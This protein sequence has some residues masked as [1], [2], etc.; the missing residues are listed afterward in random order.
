MRLII[1]SRSRSLY[2]TRRL[3]EAA[4][5]RGYQVQIIDPL[6]CSLLV[7][8]QGAKVLHRQQV[9][10]RPNALLARIGAS[11]TSYGLTV[12]RQFESQGVICTNGSLGIATARDK[13]RALQLLS[14]HHLP[15]PTTAFIRD[16][17]DLKAAIETVGGLPVVLKVVEGTQ[18]VGVMLADSMPMAASI[19]DTFLRQGQ[20]VL[21]QQ[22]VA[23]SK[24]RDVRAFV[25]G[26][27][28]VAAMLRQASGSEF[29][30][31]LHRG[32]QAQPI[33][34][35]KNY[36]D[37][38]LK[39]AHILSLEVAGVDLLLS[40]EGPKVLEVN[41]SP[42]LEGIE[43]ASGVD[44]AGAVADFVAAQHPFNN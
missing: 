7:N 8:A 9:L 12:V 42:G 32:A 18:G 37:V 30:S 40:H 36:A 3:T 22:Y 44:V 11:I 4:R 43:K 5:S 31:N 34:L 27:Q 25:V 10:R 17:L 26:N 6:A 24:G 14:L 19:V 2:S 1:L 38:A 39:A 23:E 20:N 21:V 41:A 28:V 16:T 15:L 35:E 13:F 33:K 29:R